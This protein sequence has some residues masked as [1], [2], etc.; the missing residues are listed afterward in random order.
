AGYAVMDF[1]GR[2]V[3]PLLTGYG[4]QH[5]DLLKKVQKHITAHAEEGGKRVRIEPN[6]FYDEATFTMYAN[7]GNENI[8][9]LTATSAD[10]I[11]NGSEG[12]LFPP[13][14]SEPMK[15]D[16]DAIRE[17]KMGMRIEPGSLAFDYFNASFDDQVWPARQW[18]QLVFCRILALFFPQAFN[19]RSILAFIGEAGCGKTILA[20]KIGWVLEG[21]QFQVDA[22]VDDN[23]EME[24]LFTSKPFV[25]LDNCDDIHQM[26]KKTS[27][28]CRTSTGGGVSRRILYSTNTHIQYPL[29]S[30]LVL[31][32]I[33]AGFMRDTLAGRTLII[34]LK[35]RNRQQDPGGHNFKT[36]AQ[37]ARDAVLTELFGRAKNILAA[38]EAQA[39]YLPRHDSRLQDLTGFIMRCAIHEDWIHVGT[40]ILK[41]MTDSQD[42]EANLNNPLHR[43]IELYI[44][45][46]HPQGMSFDQ[47]IK[48]T[49]LA[50]RLHRAAQAGGINLEFEATAVI[51]RSKINSQLSTLEKKFGLRKKLNRENSNDYWF[52]PTQDV[53]AAC[54]ELTAQLGGGIRELAFGSL[55][56]D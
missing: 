19:T 51:M 18:L 30:N 38:L 4:L 25:V 49:A 22:V 54:R 47:P 53:V 42:E 37:A 16:L 48:M 33:S 44:G 43:A 21:A 6:Y 41:A 31:T 29:I 40:E 14:S 26:K 50:Q 8:L 23:K 13:Y 52:E 7:V 46:V 32:A 35:P 5:D 45:S 9:K 20:E 55:D 10:F 24:T 36:Q 28:L 27:L 39:K 56:E 3:I 17:S 34:P 15:L 12:L 1:R 11:P 2:Q